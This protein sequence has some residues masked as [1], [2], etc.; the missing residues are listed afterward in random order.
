MAIQSAKGQGTLKSTL[1]FA[2]NFIKHPRM[3]GSMIPSSRFLVN[4]LLRL[5]DWKAAKVI[6]EYGPG[7]GV[8]TKEIVQRMAPDA[9]LIVVE[10]NEEFVGVLRKTMPDS[11]LDVVHGSAADIRGILHERGI[12]HAD[13]VISGIPYSLMPAEVRDAIIAAT[14]AVLRPGGRFL[15]FQYSPVAL[16][17]VRRVFDNVKLDFELLNILPATL[18]I[19]IR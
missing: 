10:T 17:A 15:V 12:E 2:R 16:P 13:Y 18:F 5:V 3:L 19:C 7:V 11:R 9:R 1:V 6:V 8:I 14:Y 4:R